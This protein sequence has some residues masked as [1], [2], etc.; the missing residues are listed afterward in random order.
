MRTETYIGI[1]AG[2]KGT[3][4]WPIS[5]EKKPKQFLD[6]LSSG[7]TLIQQTYERAK[8][9]VEP[10]NIAIISASQYLNIIQEQLPEITN[11]QLLLEPIGRN[12]APSVA[13]ISFKVH[14]IDPDANIIILPSD[15]YIYPNENFY[16]TLNIILEGL[17]KHPDAIFTIGI[18]P[19]YPATGYGYIQFIKDDDN[20]S[21]DKYYKVK[22]FTEKPALEIA[23]QF[24]NSGEFLWNSGMF[25]FKAEG[26]INNFK[27][28]MPDLYELFMNHYN[29]FNTP[30][31]VE[32]ITDIYSKCLSISFDFGIM[33][34]AEKVFVIPSK[35]QWS[36]VGT[37]KALYDI[38]TKDENKNVVQLNEYFIDSSYGNLL[39]SNVRDKFYAIKDLNDFILVDTE[40]ALLLIPLSED[41]FVKKIIKKLQKNN[42]YV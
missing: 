3:R 26:I 42:K 2:G 34:H 38:S 16:Y 41:Q 27:K 24:L 19:T 11:Q 5:R 28:Y 7:K 8:G 40:D 15:H 14:K 29:N 32:A 37:W 22:T 10:K 13:Y 33:E 35:F 39:V 9:F 21:P 17:Q 36:D 18:Q 31:E 30:K 23:K 20:I 1:L 6:I 25:V 12:T 4:F